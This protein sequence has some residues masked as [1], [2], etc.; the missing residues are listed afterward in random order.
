[1]QTNLASMQVGVVVDR[2]DTLDT[3][4][5]FCIFADTNTLIFLHHVAELQLAEVL[6]RW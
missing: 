5:S 4:A 2:V 3:L 6:S 1:M